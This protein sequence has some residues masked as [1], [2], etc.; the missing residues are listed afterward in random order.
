MQFLN[1][2]WMVGDPEVILTTAYV[3]FSMEVESPV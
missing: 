2:P 3:P 1:P